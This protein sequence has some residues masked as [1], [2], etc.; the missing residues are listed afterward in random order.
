MKLGVKNELIAF[1]Y[2]YATISVKANGKEDSDEPNYSNAMVHLELESSL[3]ELPHPS[4]VLSGDEAPSF[5]GADPIFIE[6]GPVDLKKAEEIGEKYFDTI[7]CPNMIAQALFFVGRELEHLT[8]LHVRIADEDN[9][10]TFSLNEKFADKCKVLKT[11]YGGV[12][13]AYDKH[14]DLE[15]FTSH[16]ESE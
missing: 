6:L 7:E 9:V 15:D 1:G 4:Y 14:M 12:K 10:I 3:K 16:E 11:Y 5:E 8:G 2:S 13:L